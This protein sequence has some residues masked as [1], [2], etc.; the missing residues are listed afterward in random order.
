M[1]MAKREIL[2]DIYYNLTD[3]YGYEIGGKMF[4]YMMQKC[5]GLNYGDANK[6]LKQDLTFLRNLSKA[7]NSIATY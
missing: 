7:S 6:M 3:N 4:L 2:G 1:K 5:Q